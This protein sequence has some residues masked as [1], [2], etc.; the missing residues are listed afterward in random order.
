LS[1]AALRDRLARLAR[2]APSSLAAKHRGAQVERVV[3]RGFEAVQTA[4]GMAWR[5]ADVL[6]PGRLPG[7]QPEVPHAYLDTETTG[8][9]GGTGT[10]VFA[11]S[12]CRPIPAGLELTQL[13]LADPSGE[14]A[15]LTLLQEELRRTERLA[16]YNGSC[17]DLPLLRTRWVMARMPG[18][19][20]HP[21]HLDLLTLTRSLMRQR[22][23]RCTLRLVEERLLGFD[24]EA[25]LTGTLVPQ[26]YFGYLRHGWSPMLPM[27]LEHNRQDVVSLYYLHAR[28][29]LR[30]AG[31]DPLMDGSDW[32]ALGRHLLRTRRRA[33]GWRAL[34]N[35]AELADGPASALAGLLLAR[36]L[37]RRRRP[38]AAERVLSAIDERMPA[39]PQVAIARA[40]LLEWSLH[41]LTAAQ[42]V[43][44]TALAGLPPRS[45]YRID[46][47]WRIQRLESKLR[48]GP[49]EFGLFDALE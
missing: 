21:H 26:A 19:L 31:A 47:E 10:Q 36:F 5:Y 23:E 44:A 40:R 41:D 25:D 9:S 13:F 38:S 20:E 42:R 27:A 24:R 16:T 18:E 2:G 45:P 8:L 39:L 28:L 30:L 17:F 49:A 32:L 7:P 15:F 48:R 11:V 12:L 3:P 14:A 6:P 33:D 34:R 22:L 29:L 35:A 4:C 1:Q 37:T 43:A 46:L